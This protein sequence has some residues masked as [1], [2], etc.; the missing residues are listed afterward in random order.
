MKYQTLFSGKDNVNVFKL[1]LAGIVSQLC[2][3][4]YVSV[5]KQ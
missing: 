4:V 2:V 1:L 5:Y 3:K